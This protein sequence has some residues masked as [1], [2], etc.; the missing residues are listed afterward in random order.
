MEAVCRRLLCSSPLT[1]LY[2]LRYASIDYV[3]RH[4]P[5]KESLLTC[6]TPWHCLS[7][8]LPAPIEKQVRSTCDQQSVCIG[9][10]FWETG[11]A[12]SIS[13]NRPLSHTCVGVYYGQLSAISL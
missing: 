4:A 9:I 13:R 2:I 8:L 1:R 5:S 3:S 12:G 11:T 7:N 6:I 10:Q